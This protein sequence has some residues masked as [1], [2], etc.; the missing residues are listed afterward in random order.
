ME[1][2]KFLYA[3]Q[4]MESRGAELGQNC[5]RLSGIVVGIVRFPIC[6]IRDSEDVFIPNKVVHT[7]HPKGFKIA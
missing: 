7:R 6:Q 1:L 4:Q 2:P 5:Q 3:V